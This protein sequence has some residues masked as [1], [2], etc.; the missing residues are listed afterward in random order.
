M[1]AAGDTFR[2]AAREQLIEWGARN[3]VT[4]ISQA[5]GDSAA[6]CFDAMHAAQARGTDIGLADTAGR[7]PT[8]LHLM[9]EIKKVKRV[10]QKSMD[11]APHEVILV[12]DANIGQNA[13]N[14]V[15]AFDDA[16]GLTGLILTKL[17]GTAKG[18]VI[19]ALAKTRPIPIRFIGVGE[20]IEDL[21]PFNARDYAE[22]LLGD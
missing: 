13:V 2:A 10:M 5:T 4:V 11:T 9:E 16:L 18:G 6:V 3:N 19:A 7:L 22:A 17:D 12:L 21:R 15:I 20:G 14:Q 8:Q 1:L